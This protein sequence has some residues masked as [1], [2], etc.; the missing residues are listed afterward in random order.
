MREGVRSSHSSLSY[1]ASYHAMRMHGIISRMRAYPPGTCTLC[2]LS[3]LRSPPTL[4]STC[5]MIP[6]CKQTSCGGMSRGI[7]ACRCCLVC[8]RIRLPECAHFMHLCLAKIHRGSRQRVCGNRRV[9]RL[10]CTSLAVH[11]AR[12]SN[13]SL[14]PA[15][16]T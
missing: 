16:I 7:M 15:L 12:P 10:Q 9:C 5:S 13:R 14:R 8:V 1:R 3:T 4:H 2:H 11:C 6:C